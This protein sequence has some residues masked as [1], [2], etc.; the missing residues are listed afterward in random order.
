MHV[1]L[2]W[3]STQGYDPIDINKSEYEYLDLVYRTTKDNRQVFIPANAKLPLGI[4][5]GP[6]LKDYIFHVIIYGRNVEP[7]EKSYYYKKHFYY[8]KGELSEHKA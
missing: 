5:L 6:P 7:L 8:D 4:N 1:V 3:V 2:C